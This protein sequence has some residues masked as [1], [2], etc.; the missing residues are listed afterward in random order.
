MKRI[1]KASQAQAIRRKELD[2]MRVETLCPY[3]EDATTLSVVC[4]SVIRHASTATKFKESA[5][6]NRFHQAFCCNLQGMKKCPQYKLLTLY[7]DTMATRRELAKAERL[8]EK[9]RGM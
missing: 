7:Y 8:L 1:K 6:L 4:N 3:F 2:N 5:Q 9:I